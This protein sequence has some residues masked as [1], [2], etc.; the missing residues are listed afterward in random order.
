MHV[1]ESK[2][3]KHLDQVYVRSF[4]EILTLFFLNFRFPDLEMNVDEELTRYKVWIFVLVY[5]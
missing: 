2:Q 1:S 5:H 4:E 3:L